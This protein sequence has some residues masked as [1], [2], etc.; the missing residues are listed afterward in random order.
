MNLRMIRH[1]NIK[2]ET[3]KL[4]EKNIREYLLNLRASKNYLD[5]TQKPI[6]I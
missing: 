6:N 2:A 1:I 3:I 4:Q 5:R